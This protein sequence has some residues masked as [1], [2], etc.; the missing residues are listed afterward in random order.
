MDILCTRCGE[1]W[2]VFSLT[3]DMS[4]E[5]AKA[6][7]AGLGCPCCVNKELCV[8]DIPCDQCPEKSESRCLAKIFK[9]IMDEARQ[10]QSALADVLGDDIDGLAATMEDFGFL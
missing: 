10:V 8:K 6:L 9:P 4:L 1:P 3:D 7:K 2:D 5:E